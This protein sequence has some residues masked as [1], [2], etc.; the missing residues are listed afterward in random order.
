MNDYTRPMGTDLSHSAPF[1]AKISES[2]ETE[3]SG[4]KMASAE[5]PIV[6]QLEPAK[7]HS[8][9]QFLIRVSRQVQVCLS[10]LYCQVHICLKSSVKVMMTINMKINL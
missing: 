8:A 7:L 5:Q 2:E 1:S 6:S 10:Q 4:G 3:Y 9:K